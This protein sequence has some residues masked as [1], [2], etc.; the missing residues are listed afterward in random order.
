[1]RKYDV[2]IIG[3]GPGGVTTALSARNTYP[4][5]SILLIRREKTPL[6]PCG[7]PY[8]FHTLDVVEDDILPD[9]PLEKNG[10]ELLVDEVAKVQDNKELILRSGE[11]IKWDK[12]VLA[13]G[14][15]PFV[16]P[17]PGI[18][19]KGVYFVKK[20]IDYLK[21][22]REEVEAARNIV[23]LGGGFIGVEVADELLKK[24][25]TV[26]LI[27]KLSSLLP[28]S[29]DAEF[30]IIVAEILKERGAEVVVG[31]SVKE[32][33]GEENVCGVKLENGKQY[34]ADVVIIAAGYRPNIELA[35]QMGLEVDPRYGI[36][37]DEYMRTSMKD[38]FAVGDCVAKR[39]FLTGEFSKLMLASTA[40]AQGRLVGS[41]LFDLKVIKEFIGT[42]GTFSTKIGDTAFGA[43]GLTETQAKSMGIDYLTGVT[44][45]LDRHPG[46]LPGASKIYIKLIYARYSHVL[47][48]AQLKGGDSVGEWI[49][50]LTVMVQ[51][52]MT[53]ME[54]DTLQIGTHPL[55]TSS[56]IAY[57][58][59]NAT[60]DAIMKWYNKSG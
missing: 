10:V 30:G 8:V 39:N 56:P 42:I 15:K 22:L 55:L 38:V 37:V 34:P 53:A 21:E 57:P 2:V 47:L 7:V 40:T 27:E 17:L 25:K 16:P 44:E 41:N 54:I 51:N 4:E 50:M 58:V 24:G 46:K 12:L 19:K 43:T 29:M 32:I 14:S 23:I 6:I 52:K 20:E 28:L 59:I 11:R 35:Q 5:K 33:I 1:M 45:V 26:V 18:D 31:T 9:K 49:N 3:G 60:V 36:I 13:L 48:G